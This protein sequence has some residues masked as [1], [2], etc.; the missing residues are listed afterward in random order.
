MSKKY[1][2]LTLILIALF[3]IHTITVG[4]GFHEI[5]DIQLTR[6]IQA[7]TP[8]IFDTAFSTLSVFGNFEFS[9]FFLIL[10]TYRSR[11]LLVTSLG[12]L[13][14]AHIVEYVLKRYLY[15]PGPPDQ[16]LRYNLPFVLPTT[17]IQPGFSY[18]SGHSLR[19]VF[20]A[21]LAGYLIYHSRKKHITKKYL[22]TL[23]TIVTLF[24]LYTRVSLGEHWTS[25]VI[26]GVLLGAASVYGLL[27]LQHHPTVSNHK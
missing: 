1:L 19:M 5:T 25:D 24:M 12:V 22:Y 6:N 14:V 15:H 26:G 16:F 2:T 21:I 13:G 10:L 27:Y 8:T 18:P 11:K 4:I 23:L 3:L 9:M 20:L 7:I 17:H